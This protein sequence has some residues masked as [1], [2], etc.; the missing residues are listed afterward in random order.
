MFERGVRKATG[1][2]GANLAPDGRGATRKVR[3]MLRVAFLCMKS[4]VN[5]TPEC[6][7]RPITMPE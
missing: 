2:I 5:Y 3:Q 7:I 4:G 1:L 6:A